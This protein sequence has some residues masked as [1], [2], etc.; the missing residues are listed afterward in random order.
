[1]DVARPDVADV[2]LL[3]DAPDVV[4]GPTYCAPNAVVDL[5]VQGTRSG[6]VTRYA[7][8]NSAMSLD[9]SLGETCISSVAPVIHR[10]TTRTAS[11]ITISTQNPGTDPNFDTVLDVLDACGPLR[12]GS[13]VRRLDCSDD[14]GGST[15][16]LASTVT[17]PSV[18]AGTTLFLA[19]SGYA[20]ATSP[21][22][23]RGPYVL[24]VAEAPLGGAGASCD[25]AGISSACETGL[26]CSTSD[27]PRCLADGTLG[28]GCRGTWPSCN[29]GLGCTGERCETASTTSS[30]A[31]VCPATSLCM[32]TGGVASCVPYGSSGGRCRPSPNTPCDAGLLCSEDNYCAPPVAVGAACDN[33]GRLNACTT[34]ASCLS[35]R[36]VAN[37]S[38]NGVCRPEVTQL[39][40]DG[41]LVC[42]S[43]CVNCSGAVCVATVP[44]GGDCSAPAGCGSNCMQQRCATGSTCLR[45][46][47]VYRC[48][49]N[50]AAGTPCLRSNAQMPC[51]DGLACSPSGYC[52]T[53]QREGDLCGS[54]TNGACGRGL[55]CVT[56]L[57]T[58]RCAPLPYVETS[59]AI[60]GYIEAC[61][62]GRVEPLALTDQVYNY[63][64]APIPIPFAF[65]YFGLAQTHFTPGTGAGGFFG[66][67]RPLTQ[68]VSFTDTAPP[69]N[70]I[71]PFA[72]RRN[73]QSLRLQ[74]TGSRFCSAT[75]GAAPNRRFA[76]E[77]N[78]LTLADAGTAMHLTFEVVL[79]ETTNVIEL[80]YRRLEP[81]TG[82]LARFTDGT[83]ADIGLA[84]PTGQPPVIH[85]GPVRTSA[86]IRFIP[87]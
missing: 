67:G 64:R 9:L 86:G 22:V 18:P 51:D 33:N 28:G 13:D 53:A 47:T 78:D 74:N 60:S 82:V 35:S 54:G 68:A 24:T 16:R 72:L 19:V 75:V 52:T 43:D 79:Q 8:S 15:L 34:G 1:M 73:G 23:P 76:V 50:G 38:L 39:T 66:T 69:V 71:A 26:S 25:R 44:V 49:A 30:C 17:L 10:Y 4:T 32:T 31:P 41:T 63:P 27:P 80:Y 85:R 14:A 12:Y 21:I 83:L 87:R 45:Q 81:S 6:T 57:G 84:G 48:V 59:A 61:E 56:A 37:G 77:W 42:S 5:A 65:S 55:A 7:G 70:M 2:P 58:S 40:C 3:P 29:A 46:D 20:R 36:C 62:V 11:R